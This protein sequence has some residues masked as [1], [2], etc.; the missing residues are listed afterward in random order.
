M[1]FTVPIMKFTRQC[2]QVQF[3]DAIVYRNKYTLSGGMWY[4]N[5]DLACDADGSTLRI[6]GA[7][8]VPDF[9]AEGTIPTQCGGSG[10]A[11]RSREYDV[12]YYKPVNH[13]C[14]DNDNDDGFLIGQLDR[15]YVDGFVPCWNHCYRGGVVDGGYQQFDDDRKR[16][17]VDDN[18]IRHAIRRT[19][20]LRILHGHDD[21]LNG[22]QHGDD[23]NY[24]VVRYDH[25]YGYLPDN[26]VHVHEYLYVDS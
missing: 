4:Q 7:N 11:G 16:N 1:N 15:I 8:F 23:D 18:C 17:A 3:T 10:V 5:A 22:D 26:C 13:Q 14:F 21:G 2:V 6:N 20:Q 9:G 19:G 12:V 24:L 25:V